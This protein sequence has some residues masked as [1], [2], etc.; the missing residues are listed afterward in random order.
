VDLFIWI[1]SP[2]QRSPFIHAMGVPFKLQG[3]QEC[4]LVSGLFFCP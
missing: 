1:A 3:F 2:P 4:S